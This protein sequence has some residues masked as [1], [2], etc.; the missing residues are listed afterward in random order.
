MTI[1]FARS[2]QTFSKYFSIRLFEL[3][4]CNNCMEDIDRTAPKMLNTHNKHLNVYFIKLFKN[5]AIVLAVNIGYT[6]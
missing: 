3:A 4:E 5:V 2:Q 6:H 1:T